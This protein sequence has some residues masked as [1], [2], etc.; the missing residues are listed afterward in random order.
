M[1]G[2]SFL[3]ERS[4]DWTYGVNRTFL[5]QALLHWNQTYDW[6]AAVKH[7]NSFP[8][9]T[10]NIM[11][12]R[13]HFWHV[14]AAR[15]DAPAVL[16]LHGWP[17]SVFEFHKVVA[18]LKG[19]FHLVVPSLPGYGW[20][21]GATVPG[22][23]PVEIAGV[24]ARLMGRL[25]YRK[26][27]VQGGDWG[28]MIAQALARV[29]P[30]AVSGLHLNMFPVAGL[31]AALGIPAML[32]A[33]ADE[34]AKLFPLKN[35][36]R[37]LLDHTGYFHEQ[38]TKP[39]TLG[40]ALSDSPAGLA[41]WILEKFQAWTDCPLPCDP[42]QVVSMDE[43]LTN[44]MIY[45]TTNSATSSVRLYKEAVNSPMFERVLN[46]A[47]R[48]PV[49]LLEFPIELLPPPKSWVDWRFTNVVSHHKATRGGHFAALEQPEALVRDL[50]A[51][52]TIQEDKK[53]EVAQFLH[54]WVQDSKKEGKIFQHDDI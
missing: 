41:A 21:D 32:L 16:L 26:Y 11:G 39:H 35:F 3:E 9:F 48:V 25:E 44:V 31:R 20:S 1:R 30:Q 4:A 8:Q 34:W 12:L 52:I 29:D 7:L 43:L 2:G 42:S 46:D 54:Q 53:A 19:E 6:E 5:R 13:I 36:I 23:C 38:A 14:K 51:F 40:V 18:S 15:E 27:Y 28:S 17:G 37:T 33:E 22:L 45:W 49:A 50:R 10:S 24:F 47:V